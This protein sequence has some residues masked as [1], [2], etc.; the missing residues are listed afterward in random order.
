MRIIVFL[1]SRG[2]YAT[3]Q[4]KPLFSLIIYPEIQLEPQPFHHP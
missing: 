1:I 4:I 3:L 2:H